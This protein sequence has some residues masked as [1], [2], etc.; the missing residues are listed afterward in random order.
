MKINK[1][2]ISVII[3]WSIATVLLFICY[4]YSFLSYGSFSPLKAHEL[5]ERTYHYGPSKIIKEIDLGKQKIYL[6]RYKDWFSADTV[7]KELIKWYPGDGVGGYPIDSSKQ[8]SYSW[9]GSSTKNN[10]MF[11]KVYGYVSDTKITTILIE[12][13]DKISEPKYQLDESRMFLFNWNKDS[14]SRNTKYLVGLDKDGK[15]IYKEELVS[16]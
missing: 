10:E 2:S 11:M 12:G 6:G 5:S 8:V 15:V 16:I 14:N 9:S 13:E 7:R 1:I 3:E 4:K